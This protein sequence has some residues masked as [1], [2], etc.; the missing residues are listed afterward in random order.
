[1]ATDFEDFFEDFEHYS[2]EVTLAR[3][4]DFARTLREWFKIFES[5]PEPLRARISWLRNLLPDGKLAS[6]IIVQGRGMVG[7]GKLNW[8][9]DLEQRLSGQLQLLEALTEKEDSA[10]QFA[11]N[12]FPGGGNNINDTLAQLVRH[13]FEPHARELRR[14]LTRN[15]DKP[16]SG[17][18]PASDRIV[19]IDHN[20]LAYTETISAISNTAD[21]LVGD[22]AIG[23]EDRDRIKFE[24]DSGMLLLQ[25]ET[26]RVGAIEAV[27]IQ[28]LRWLSANFAGAALGIAAERALLAVL[29]LISGG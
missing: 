26:V 8:P 6:E 20:Q 19:R 14:Y 9:D 1:M 15:V 3:H 25:A 21:A 17:D 4:Q 12:F 2:T 7:S 11:F 10:W 29:A 18:V 27:L 24:L 22:N 16:L 23:P 13:L 28:A 5:A